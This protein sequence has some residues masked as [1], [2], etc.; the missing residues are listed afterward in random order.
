MKRI[1]ESKD[2]I[3]ST[4]TTLQKN[5]DDLQGKQLAVFGWIKPQLQSDE[6]FY[7]VAY[8]DSAEPLTNF[9]NQSERA[10]ISRQFG[11]KYIT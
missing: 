9:P 5:E 7:V 8:A 10:S 3:P 11:N 1:I 4:L 6:K 2:L